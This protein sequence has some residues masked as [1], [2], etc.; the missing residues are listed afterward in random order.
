MSAFSS[1]IPILYINRDEDVD[2]RAYMEAQFESLGIANA[3]R[4]PAFTG[5]LTKADPG[6]RLQIPD[7]KTNVFKAIASHLWAIQSLDFKD[8]SYAL[9][10]EDDVVLTTCLNWDFTLEEFCQALPEG[11]DAVQLYLNPR[12][13]R[14]PETVSLGLRPYTKTLI[15]TV[16][17][18]ITKEKAEEIKKEWF[19]VGVPDLT[20]AH[21]SFA[22]CLTDDVVY[23][24]A[25]YG[26]N[27]FSTQEFVSTIITKIPDRFHENS[28]EVIRL[29]ESEP[30][31]LDEL[32]KAPYTKTLP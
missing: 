3:V 30:L 15:S 22:S 1:S 21:R 12:D 5:E 20:K 14:R 28:R 31:S 2:R 16:A 4:F 25:S 8:S 10:L 32:V 6:F 17:Y 13:T 24:Y 9:I 19:R 29:W 7:I 23:T 11:W 18:L 26:A 27:L